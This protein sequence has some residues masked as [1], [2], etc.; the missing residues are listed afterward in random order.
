MKEQ[1]ISL[2]V[3]KLAKE[4]AFTEYCEGGYLRKEYIKSNYDFT[5]KTMDEFYLIHECHYLDKIPGQEPWYHAPTQTILRTWLREKYD[6]HIIIVPT[7]KI[8]GIDRQYLCAIM[9]D[10]YYSSTDVYK[11]YE[12]AVEF[13]LKKSLKTIK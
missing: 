10:E 11:T 3:A 9:Y 1:L 13:G 7:A 4:K 6:I 8:E 12:A 5:P 2:E